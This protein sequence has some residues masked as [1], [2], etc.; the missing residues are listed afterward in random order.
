MTFKLQ[1][2]EGP[3]DLLLFLLQK[4][5]MSIYDIEVSKITDQYM[6]YINE[7]TELELDQIAD[8]IVMASTLL[9][10]KS[11]MLLPN[12][13]QTDDEPEEDPREELIRKLL[14]YKKIKY[15]SKELDERQ[16]TSYC[17]RNQE[18]TNDIEQPKVSTDEVLAGV[19]LKQL[20]DTF[21][22]LMTQNKLT[23]TTKAKT[24]DTEILQKDVYTVTEKSTYILE[25]L[26]TQKEI[27]FFS[28]CY[29]NMP[30]VEFI[31]TFMSLLE[32]VHKREIVVEQS[33]D[34]ILIRKGDEF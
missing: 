17:F 3:L 8:F 6:H 20:L 10:I 19:S 26:S 32:L 9:L 7:A 5:K 25:M 28:L 12:Q 34:D 21:N 1:D 22:M 18:I 29:K 11:K 4:N 23:A 24:I 15:I 2:F 16:I 33:K 14:E 13:K 30:K 27:T 31:V